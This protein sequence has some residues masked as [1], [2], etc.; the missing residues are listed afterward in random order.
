MN[1]KVARIIKN[2]QSQYSDI[3]TT[4]LFGS[5]TTPGWTKD[6]DVDIF[7]ID[8]KLKDSREDLIIDGITIEL[9]K[10][11]FANLAKD[12][13]RERGSLLHRNLA[14]MIATSVIIKS[15]SQPQVH[16]LK[17]LAKDVL[18]SPSTYTDDDVK[19]WR[20]S[21]QDY[22]AKAA[23]DVVRGDPLAFYLDAHYVIQNALELSLATHGAYL[24]QPKNLTDLLQRIDP[25]LLTILQDYLSAPTLSVKLQAL[26]LLAPAQ[27]AKENPAAHAAG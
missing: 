15:D 14:T 8:D 2:L 9:Q 16:Q 4:L 11:N 24:P 19:M 6:S 10:D 13:E 18:A 20:Y 27:T 22:L 1:N 25:P 26:T 17:S 5:A 23:K 3:D 7:L 21:I 12:L